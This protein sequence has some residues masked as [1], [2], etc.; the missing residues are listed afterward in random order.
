MLSREQAT[1]LSQAKQ[2]RFGFKESLFTHPARRLFP[3]RVSRA[4]RAR[5]ARDITHARVSLLPSM[6]GALRLHVTS[7]REKS[8]KAVLHAFIHVLG[9]TAV[10]KG[11]PAPAHDLVTTAAYFLHERAALRT[12]AK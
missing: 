1:K 10:A 5:A 9:P 3:F 2:S 7:L 12:P 4:A 6:A 8:E 11:A